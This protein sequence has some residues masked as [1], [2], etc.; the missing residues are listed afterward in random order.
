[1]QVMIT[2]GS[3]DAELRVWYANLADILATF[4]LS[5]SNSNPGWG[6]TTA[7]SV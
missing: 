3:G 1:M 5:T 7:T 6:A 4:Y 2:Y